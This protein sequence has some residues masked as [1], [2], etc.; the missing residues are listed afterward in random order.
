[1]KIVTKVGIL[2]ATVMM[3]VGLLGSPAE[4][5]DT[6]WGCPGCRRLSLSRQHHTVET[7]TSHPPH[8]TWS[9]RHPPARLDQHEGSDTRHCPR[10]IS[11]AGSVP[12]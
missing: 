7:G 4:A 9:Q 5:K 2:A 1:M 8:P 11:R 3:S 12:G 10:G 6:S